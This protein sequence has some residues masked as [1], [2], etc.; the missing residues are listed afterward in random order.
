MA[1]HELIKVSIEF[2]PISVPSMW[3]DS[4]IRWSMNTIF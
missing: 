3:K 1:C 4:A 2:V